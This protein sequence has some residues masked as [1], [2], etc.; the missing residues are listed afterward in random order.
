MRQ[1]KFTELVMEELV[2]PVRKLTREEKIP[3]AGQIP[4]ISSIMIEQNKQ[5]R[6]EVDALILGQTPIA[7]VTQTL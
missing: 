3:L 5:F 4:A 6:A 1:Q 2:D 7:G